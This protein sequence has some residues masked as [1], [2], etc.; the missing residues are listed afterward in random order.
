[1]T[2]E[3]GRSTQLEALPV[4]PELKQEEMGRGGQELPKG[5]IKNCSSSELRDKGMPSR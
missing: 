3:A 4:K 1:M 5:L 2:T